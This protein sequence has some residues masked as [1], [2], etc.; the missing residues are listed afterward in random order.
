MDIGI[1]LENNEN[2]I[3]FD[4]E[5]LLRLKNYLRNHCHVGIA[6]DPVNAYFQGLDV[7]ATLE[8]LVGHMD[9]MH[10]KN[11]LRFDQK[12]WGYIPRGDYS[13]EWTSLADGDIDWKDLL[14]KARDGGFDGPMVFEYVNPLKGMPLPY[15]NTLR[16]PAQAARDEAAF[17][18]SIL[19]A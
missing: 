19:D 15:W 17:L 2:T 13:Y 3:T 5:S 7:E 14:C 10:L 16:E 11:V 18:Q 4:A 12:R 8:K 6:Y 1:L 9:M